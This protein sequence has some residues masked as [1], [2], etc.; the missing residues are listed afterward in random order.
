MSNEPE[1]ILDEEMDLIEQ[2]RK[3]EKRKENMAGWGTIVSAFIYCIPFA[4]LIDNPHTRNKYLLITFLPYVIVVTFFLAWL[5]PDNPSPALNKP[6]HPPIPGNEPN[7]HNLK[8][9]T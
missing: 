3:A 1:H 4:L 2:E 7:P 6:P 5:I 9:W 8:Q